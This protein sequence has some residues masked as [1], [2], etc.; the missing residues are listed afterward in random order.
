MVWVELIRQVTV[1]RQYDLG[2]CECG[3]WMRAED[4]D[5]VR[6]WSE[7]GRECYDVG[8]DELNGPH[9]TRSERP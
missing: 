4:V 8:A 1:N 9:K 7:A 2:V 5:D 6:R 3:V